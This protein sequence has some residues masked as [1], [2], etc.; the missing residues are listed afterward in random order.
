MKYQKLPCPKP[1]K[2]Y[3]TAIHG[4]MFSTVFPWEVRSGKEKGMTLKGKMVFCNISGPD[5]IR[6]N[7]HNGGAET[8]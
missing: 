1:N 6:G 4:D 8:K 7:R 5:G 3:E 2:S